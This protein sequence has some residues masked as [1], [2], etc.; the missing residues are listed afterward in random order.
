MV[1]K[2]PIFTVDWEAWHSAIDPNDDSKV[3]RIAEPTYY[4]LG[5]L[6]HLKVTAIFYVLGQMVYKN[7]EIYE[8]I[9]QEG[10]VIGWH[11][12]RHYHNLKSETNLFRSPYWDTTPMPWPPSGGFFFRL[13]PL[14]YVKYAIK[15][16]GFFWIHPHD[17]DPDHPET[18]DLFLNWKRHFGLKNVRLKLE[19]LLKQVT[20]G[21]PR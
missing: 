17:L 11:G 15:K 16:S 19:K 12:M 10:H 21:D 2:F 6:R 1:K 8:D 4:L 18:S 5:L 14:T 3:D 9:K 20:F 13:M 7:P